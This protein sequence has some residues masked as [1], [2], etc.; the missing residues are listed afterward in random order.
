[1]LHQLFYRY[2]IA[3]QDL[4]HFL[5]TLPGLLFSAQAQIRW[6]KYIQ[7]MI[8]LW[9]KER[10]RVAVETHT[11][12]M[13]SFHNALAYAKL[14]R[15][16]NGLFLRYYRTQ[17]DRLDAALENLKSSMEHYDELYGLFVSDD[18]NLLV[19]EV[20]NFLQEQ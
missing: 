12:I 6:G 19:R 8:R 9:E 3:S 11:A 7:E 16:T 14:V 15:D 10:E 5:Q 20:E 13:Y 18:L 4:G 1:M 2:S 17:T